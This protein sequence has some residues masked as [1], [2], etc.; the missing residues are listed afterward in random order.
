MFSK[1]RKKKN[2]NKNSKELNTIRVARLLDDKENLDN[3]SMSEIKS[4]LK[5]VMIAGEIYFFTA[6]IYAVLMVSNPLWIWMYIS[7]IYFTCKQVDKYSQLKELEEK[8]TE[9]LE[10]KE[11]QAKKNSL[12]LEE[13][14]R[15]FLRVL[16]ARPRLTANNTYCKV[17]DARPYFINTQPTDPFNPD[18]WYNQ[19]QTSGKTLTRRIS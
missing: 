16:N 14:T 8:Y 19:G 7:N 12:L 5:D 2:S 6:C 3:I 15:D 9:Y 17:V 1:L 10:E 11:A 13:Q 18:Y 4:R